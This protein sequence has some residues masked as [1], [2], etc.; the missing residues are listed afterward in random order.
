MLDLYGHWSTKRR[1]S[2]GFPSIHRRSVVHVGRILLPIRS[3]DAASSLFVFFVCHSIK[4]ML[5]QFDVRTI[6]RGT[7]QRVAACHNT[8]WVVVSGALSCWGTGSVPVALG[9]VRS[10]VW[11]GTLAVF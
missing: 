11:C 3:P 2:T 6:A 7:T 1:R 8:A 10:C 9:V 5:L 4:K